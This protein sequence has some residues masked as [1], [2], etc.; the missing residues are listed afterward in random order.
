VYIL[1]IY[2]GDFERDLKMPKK[3]KAKPQGMLAQSVDG[4]SMILRDGMKGAKW[5]TNNLRKELQKRKKA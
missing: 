3:K 4:W 2:Y 5:A 1:C